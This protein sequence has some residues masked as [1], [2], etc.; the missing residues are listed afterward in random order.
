MCPCFRA[1]FQFVTFFRPNSTQKIFV[2]THFLPFVFSSATYT[3]W[4]LFVLSGLLP[5]SLLL[6]PRLS[7]RAPGPLT[8]P[9]AWNTSL[10]L[11]FKPLAMPKPSAQAKE[12]T[13]PLHLLQLVMQLSS[14]IACQAPKPGSV[15][16]TTSRKGQNLAVITP[17][18]TG[19][20][21]WYVTYNP[22]PK[23]SV[24]FFVLLASVCSCNQRVATH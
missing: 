8:S 5:P 10:W 22:S 7:W 19:T 1:G 3:Q 20:A 11:E 14:C 2:Y 23:Y 4:A 17:S 12:R 6:L 21:V 18:L 16:T 24:R 15:S 13:L 9:A